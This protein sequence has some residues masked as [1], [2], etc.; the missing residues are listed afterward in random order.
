MALIGR[1]GKIVLVIVLS[2]IFFLLLLYKNDIPQEELIEKYTYPESH[3]IEVDGV[4][5]HARLVGQGE[6]V[7]LLHGS[8]SSLHTWNEWQ[9]EMSPYF[10]T[11][12]IDLPGHG[13]TGPDELKRYTISDYGQFVLRLAEKLNLKK[14]HIAGNSLGGAVALEVATTRPDQVLS[15]NLIDAAGAPQIIPRQLESERTSNT[16]SSPWIFRAMKNP[17]F[18]QLFLKCTPKFLFSMNIQ[19]VYGDP[20]KI[21]A[22]TI[23]RYYDLMLREGNRQATL[24]RL[25][26]PRESTF[27]FSR[28]E[29]PIVIMWGDQDQWIPVSNAMEFKKAIPQ[30]NLVVFEGAGHVPMEEIP[31]QSVAEYLSFLGVEIRKDYLQ[32]PKL[33]TYAD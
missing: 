2:L 26:I 21:R 32:Q 24:D 28:L 7:I 31:T 18:S 10:L 15:L 22:H 29:M 23:D 5:I 33:M 17:I 1:I 16:S 13:L 6:P 25:S 8:F 9:Q 3:F 12:S 4:N 14:Y 19:D 30:A 11:I 20:E 27:D